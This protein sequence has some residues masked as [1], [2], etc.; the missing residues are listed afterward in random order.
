MAHTAQDFSFQQQLRFIDRDQRISA[1]R[2]QLNST[3]RK[4][5][6]RVLHRIES[7][8]RVRAIRRSPLRSVSMP[9]RT[10]SCTASSHSGCTD[11][12]R[13]ALRFREPFSVGLLVDAQQLQPCVARIAGELEAGMVKGQRDVESRRGVPSCECWCGG[14]AI[15]RGRCSQRSGRTLTPRPALPDWQDPDRSSRSACAPPA[16]R[17]PAPTTAACRCAR[18]GRLR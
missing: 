3:W 16:G 17:A 6:A 12:R 5:S 10:S 13:A 18:G 4:R 9:Q 15:A 2:I 1:P 11:F 14:D 7:S 8:C